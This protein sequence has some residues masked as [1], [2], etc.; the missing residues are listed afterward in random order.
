MK[1]VLVLLAM[2]LGAA[3]MYAQDYDLQG[4][5]KAC[6]KYSTLSSFNEGT[7]SS[8]DPEIGNIF[9]DKKGNVVFVLE[10][11]S[12][13]GEFSEGLMAVRFLAN[14]EGVDESK[15]EFNKIG[16]I[17]KSGNLVIPCMYDKANPFYKGFAYVTKGDK[18]FYID[19]HGKEAIVVPNDVPTNELE[20][21]RLKHEVLSDVLSVECRNGKYGI[22][23]KKTG[24]NIIPFIYDDIVLNQEG[25]I[26]VN[27][28]GKF[29]WI[30]DK[31]H[32][33][34]PIQ[35]DYAEDF[36]EGLA[37]VEYNSNQGF[38]DKQG[39]STF[40]PPASSNTAQNT[41][42]EAIEVTETMPS[43][44]GGQTAMFRWISEHLQYPEEAINKGIKGRVV[45][46]FYVEKDGTI[47][48]VE[49]EKSVHPLLDNE[50]IR[51]LKSM[52]KWIPGTQDGSPVRVKY[53]VPLTY[54][55][56]EE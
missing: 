5:A 42:T 32:V 49:I 47:G 54:N 41:N 15:Y 45:A 56:T 39:N 46:S 10:L 13:E 27:Q 17:D 16:Y 11:L 8:F 55:F 33:V 43:F 38:V 1:K 36:S 21:L 28:N 53:T 7:T 35:Y 9:I 26:K 18:K 29:G 22:N 19:K 51:L 25:L 34:I 2:V 48:N 12:I 40:N 6:K 20:I 14:I 24:A 4:L 30:D 52:P 50:T 44:V 23:N 37:F 3:N 31:G